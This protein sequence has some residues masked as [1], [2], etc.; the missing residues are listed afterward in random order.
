MKRII[1]VEWESTDDYVSHKIPLEDF[2]PYKT[3]FVA[4]IGATDLTFDIL[5]APG[6]DF[7]PT[8]TVEKTKATLSGNTL[9]EWAPT[10][11]MHGCFD[12]R[13]KNAAANTP[14]WYSLWVVA[15]D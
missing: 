11:R 9:V 7:S 1:A 13:I 14:S 5:K 4:N 10:A 12:V 6:A 2:G 8:W 15:E 3:V